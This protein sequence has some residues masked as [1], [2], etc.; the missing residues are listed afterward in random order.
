[1]NGEREGGGRD[2]ITLIWQYCESQ[3]IPEVM[4][5][6]RPDGHPPS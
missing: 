4:T 1:M 2:A 5:S 3:L 6:L